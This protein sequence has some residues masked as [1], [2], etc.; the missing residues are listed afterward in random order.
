MKLMIKRMSAC[1][2]VLLWL[3]IS[4]I[5]FKMLSLILICCI[6][7]LNHRRMGLSSIILIIQIITNLVI[8]VIT[9]WNIIISD[10]NDILDGI[11]DYLLGS[12]IVINDVFNFLWCSSSLIASLIIMPI[13]KL[14][15]S[16]LNLTNI[17]TDIVLVTI[18]NIWIL[19]SEGLIIYNNSRTLSLKSLF[20]WGLIWRIYCICLYLRC[21]RY[22]IW[23]ALIICWRMTK[24]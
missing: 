2:I 3:F 22:L 14:S 12:F 18:V 19:R 17:N 8:V 9:L 24:I 11:N 16:K 23:L 6:L 4:S 21:L 5:S 10:L 7:L 15:F 13:G 20:I 1:C